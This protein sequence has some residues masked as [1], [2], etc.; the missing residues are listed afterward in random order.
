[1]SQTWKSWLKGSIFPS[2]S[3][4]LLTSLNMLCC[5]SSFL[6]LTSLLQTH[7]SQQ[8]CWLCEHQARLSRSCSAM[9]Q[10]RSGTGRRGPGV[11]HFCPICLRF[12][13]TFFFWSAN[14]IDSISLTGSICNVRASRH[15]V[16]LCVLPA[17]S[18][19]R[20]VLGTRLENV[21]MKAPEDT[22]HEKTTKSY[23]LSF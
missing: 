15:A 4:F 11:I 10:S 7:C 17:G 2:R 6:L 13:P 5:Y 8:K 14:A 19:N 18:V 22:L 20:L 23:S 3:L 9:Y 1:M 21:Q 12:C 16:H